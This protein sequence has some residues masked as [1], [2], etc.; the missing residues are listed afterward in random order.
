MSANTTRRSSTSAY[1]RDWKVSDQRGGG[2][3]NSKAPHYSYDESE[4]RESDGTYIRSQPTRKKGFFK[5]LF[6]CTCFEFDEGSD[7]VARYRPRYD[8]VRTRSLPE[9]VPP[10]SREDPHP[11]S[12]PFPAADRSIASLDSTTS[13]PAQDQSHLLF[14]SAKHPPED[15]TQKTYASPNGSFAGGTTGGA[16]ARGV[17]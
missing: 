11:P 5:K 9:P 1:S 14:L 7:P 2:T 8:A 6:G 10:Y 16:G 12:R 3:K 17:C 4:R 13:F 15:E